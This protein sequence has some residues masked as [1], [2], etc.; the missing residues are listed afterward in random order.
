MLKKTVTRSIRNADGT[1][2]PYRTIVAKNL[3]CLTVNR[4]DMMWKE[5]DI[6]ALESATEDRGMCLH[7]SG[8]VEY[9]SML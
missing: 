2:R 9:C 1:S 6:A 8:N 7:L 4:D 5:S 3:H